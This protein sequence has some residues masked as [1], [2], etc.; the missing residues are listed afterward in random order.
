M[1][2]DGFGIV[3]LFFVGFDGVIVLGFGLYLLVYFLSGGVMFFFS[4]FLVFKWVFLI[5]F[6]FVVRVGFFLLWCFFL[7]N[8]RYF[9]FVV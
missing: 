7:F 3:V 4:C 2:F 9:Y 1:L 6:F 5:L 8:C